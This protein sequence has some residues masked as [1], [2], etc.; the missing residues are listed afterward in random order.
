MKNFKNLIILKKIEPHTHLLDGIH[1]ADVLEEVRG[2]IEL[3]DISKTSEKFFKI[4]PTDKKNFE[5]H[6]DPNSKTLFEHFRKNPHKPIPIKELCKIL[7]GEYN[8][9][10]RNAIY[11]YIRKLRVFLGDDIDKPQIL[12]KVQKGYYQFDGDEWV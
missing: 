3:K 1:L 9:I 6:L 4:G 11:V 2:I 8:K 7:W 5:S 12:K 10:R